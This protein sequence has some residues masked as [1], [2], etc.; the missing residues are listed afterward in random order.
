MAEK[1]KRSL[2]AP[3]PDKF[4]NVLKALVKGRPIKGPKKGK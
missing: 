3:I 2:P 4:E 1:Q